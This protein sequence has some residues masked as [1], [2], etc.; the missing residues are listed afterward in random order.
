MSTKNPRY[1]YDPFLE[2]GQSGEV[3]TEEKRM[4]T[5]VLAT[6]ERPAAYPPLTDVERIARHYGIS[7]R[8]ACEWLKYHTVDEL[9]PE[10]GT[11]AETGTRR[12]RPEGPVY[13]TEPTGQ[14]IFP[15]VEVEGH[16]DN[17]VPVGEQIKLRAHYRASSNQSAWE[18]FVDPFWTTSVVA[19][20]DGI[21]VKNDTTQFTQTVTEHPSINHPSFPLMPNKTITLEVTLY[22]HKGSFMRYPL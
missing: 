12:P 9:L 10:R 5:T 16:P 6:L 14:F 22:G 8:E 19:R 20:G 13:Q 15:H 21:A 3:V 18:I 17:V 11:G 2:P 7:V 1:N 4:A